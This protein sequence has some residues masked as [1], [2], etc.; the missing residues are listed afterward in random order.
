MM[1]EGYRASVSHE[2]PPESCDAR[3]KIQACSASL[4]PAFRDIVREN[5]IH[6]KSGR[7][8]TH[9]NA[10]PVSRS[11]C[12]CS[13][14]SCFSLLPGIAIWRDELDAGSTNTT[15]GWRRHRSG[16]SATARAVGRA[17]AVRSSDHQRRQIRPRRLHRSFHQRQ[18]LLRDSQE[19]T[20]Q[21]VSL[22]EPDREDYAGRRLW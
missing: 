3:E 13:I 14:V 15:R 22:G 7:S 12:S 2:A 17:E 16:A 9:A 6:P 21:G 10:T 8:L 5:L 18:S 4:W 20:Q 11:S 1:V 19:R